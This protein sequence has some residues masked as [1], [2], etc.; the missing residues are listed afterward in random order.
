MRSHEAALPRCWLDFGAQRQVVPH[1]GEKKA[2][3]AH[4]CAPLE[5][6]ARGV[7]RAQ[8]GVAHWPLPLDAHIEGAGTHFV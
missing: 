6:T 2:T 5:A 7:R 1:R 8:I 3:L 4:K